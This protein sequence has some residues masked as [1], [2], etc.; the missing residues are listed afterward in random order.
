MMAKYGR[1][2]M[3]KKFGVKSVPAMWLIDKEGKVA[4]LNARSNLEAEVERLLA[5]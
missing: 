1:T 5:K 2:S 4:S 3:P